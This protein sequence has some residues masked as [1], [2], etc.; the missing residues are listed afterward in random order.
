M[1]CA[2][3]MFSLV[4]DET[5]PPRAVSMSFAWRSVR[6]VSKIVGVAQCVG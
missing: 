1:A 3:A 5:V 6:S 2:C 4:E